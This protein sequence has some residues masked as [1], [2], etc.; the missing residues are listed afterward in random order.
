[1]RWVLVL[2]ACLPG[3]AYAHLDTTGLGPVYDGVSHLLLSPD[4]L[5]PVLAM[6]ALAGLNGPAAG[7]RTLFALTLAWLAGGLAGWA[8]GHPIIPGAATIASFLALG[9]LVALDRRL[10]PTIVTAIAVALGLLHGW[11]NGAG[12]AGTSREALALAGIGAS[13]FVIVALV[14]AGILVT[15][16]GWRRIAVRVLGS[17]VAAVGLLMLGWMLRSVG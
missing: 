8:V 1:V 3:I 17:W 11:L 7:R 9:G 5:I 15:A 6:A 12:I 14:A 4:D 2:L 10:S 16:Q 13:V